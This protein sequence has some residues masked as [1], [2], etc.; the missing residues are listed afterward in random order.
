MAAVST[1]LVYAAVIGAIVSFVAGAIY[2][3]RA[4][5]GALAIVWNVF[6]DTAFDYRLLVVGVLLPDLL[7]APFGGA[8]LAHTLL[9]SVVLLVVVMSRKG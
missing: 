7:D 6:H 9:F 2:A 5:A 3:A 1:I 8:R 4:G